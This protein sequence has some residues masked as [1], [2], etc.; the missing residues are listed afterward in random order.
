MQK[1]SKS[2]R[3]LR[4]LL[5]F[6]LILYPF[7]AVGIAQSLNDAELLDIMTKIKKARSE[8]TY[9]GM[10]EVNGGLD[11]RH[12]ML[13]K[14]WVQPPSVYHM[15]S[16]SLPGRGR[17]KR[18]RRDF[19]GRDRAPRFRPPFHRSA[20]EFSLLPR[21]KY[22]SLFQQNY[23][24]D[25][26]AD[27]HIAGRPT[28]LLTIKPNHLPRF[29]MRLWYDNSNHLILKREIVYFEPDDESISFRQKF[30]E[31]E[32]AE[33]LPDSIL[34]RAQKRQ[35][36]TRRR[37]RRSGQKLEAIDDLTNKTD[38]AVFVP[39]YVPEGCELAAINHKK[40]NGREIIHLH[41][42]DG[43]LGFSIFEIT[44]PPPESIKKLLNRSP[45][46]RTARQK[47]QQMVVKQQ[48]HHSF[49][50]LGNF[51]RVQ[52]RKIANSLEAQH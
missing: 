34:E 17:D 29:G 15:E 1:I 23:I 10:V 38:A 3:R 13:F 43:L 42:T 36:G 32:Y 11:E 37:G 20:S 27:E 2:L 8:L 21:E 22:L 30:Q 4:F 40:E 14:I 19:R 39:Q 50:V 31:I 6:I 5:G 16:Y 24:A 28:T 47:F 45:R 26:R 48:N 41:Y 44:G 7:S 33:A 46:K 51:P 12:T 9:I 18:F 25:L 52:L 35:A 49:L